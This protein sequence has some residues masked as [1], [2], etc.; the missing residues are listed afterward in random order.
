M[1]SKRHDKILEI[2]KLKD[3]ETQEDLADALRNE[4]FDVTQATV[5]RDI[6]NLR[7]IKMQA[8]NGKY[9]YAVPTNESSKLT[10]KLENILANAVT[11][12]ENIDKMVVVKTFTG[13]ASAA[14]EAIDSL[15]FEDIAGTVAGDNTIFILVR[16]TESVEIIVQ[17]IKSRING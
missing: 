5:S 2:I 16:T 13:G 14:A 17:R 10:D 8:A 12:V 4:G 15:G 11:H 7:L 6:K 9:K 1:K 3:I